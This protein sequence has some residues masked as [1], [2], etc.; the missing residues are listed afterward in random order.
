MVLLATITSGVRIQCR[1]QI[2]D[3]EEDVYYT[4][5]VTVI[6]MENPT[7]V[8][9]IIGIH[10]E[11]KH[12][13][14]VKILWAFDFIGHENLTT[15]PNGI[16][17]FFTNLESFV[18]WDGNI[19]SVDSSTFEA[20]SNLL[21]IQIV[22]TKIV[23]LDGDLF[24][25]TRKLQMVHFP[26]NK[27]EHVGHDLLTGLTDLTDVWIENNPC[28][29][30]IANTPEKIQ[31][32]NLQLP[33]KCPPLATTPAPPECPS[34]SEPNECTIRCA[35]NKEA[36]EMNDRIEKLENVVAEL[37]LYQCSHLTN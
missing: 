29:D 7:T 10:M 6:S 13:E 26:G 28:I 34:T 19:S 18:W 16:G 20:F 12:N 37:S 15:I 8:T 3:E 33:I 17:N 35:T 14:D 2:F 27:L 4:C 21:V 25:Y 36:D 23:T 11:G 30:V 9:D 1:Y 24:K 5:E 22:G 31:E 32:L